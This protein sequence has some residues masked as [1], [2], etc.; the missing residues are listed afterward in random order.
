M[1]SDTVKSAHPLFEPIII[2][3]DVLNV[4]DLGD[5]P[6]ACGQIDRTVGDAHF[7]AAAPNA[8][9]LSVQSIASLCDPA[10]PALCFET[11][12]AMLAPK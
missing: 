7:R 5:N 9:P 4:V 6:N 8:L 3:I 1:C 2:G 11:A 10:I 12:L